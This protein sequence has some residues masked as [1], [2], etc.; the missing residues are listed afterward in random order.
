MLNYLKLLLNQHKHLTL[1]MPLTRHIFCYKKL[2]KKL[3]DHYTKTKKLLE[4]RVNNI[5]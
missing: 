4:V 2:V 5:K 1:A 3:L